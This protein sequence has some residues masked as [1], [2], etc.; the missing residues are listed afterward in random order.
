MN[1]EICCSLKV[2]MAIK[3]ERNSTKRYT[4][5]ILT[6]KTTPKLNSIAIHFN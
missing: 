1:A 6:P 2:E 3:S 4:H 5:T